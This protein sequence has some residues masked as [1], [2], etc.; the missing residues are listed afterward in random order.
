MSKMPSTPILQILRYT[1]GQAEIRVRAAGRRRLKWATE[2]LHS[3]GTETDQPDLTHA[4]NLA[5]GAITK[6]L[7]RLDDQG[8]LGPPAQ[9][10]EPKP[11]DN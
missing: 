5:Q 10:D 8:R 7:M 11:D 9:N 3:L 1:N 6:I 4:A 2:V